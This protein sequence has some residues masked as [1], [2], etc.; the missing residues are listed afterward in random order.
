M[1][2][3]IELY[4]GDE[5]LETGRVACEH[6]ASVCRDGR[7]SISE[8]LLAIDERVVLECV[9]PGRVTVNND[10]SLTVDRAEATATPLA[11]G[12][13]ARRRFGCRS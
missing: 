3:R 6:G 13:V 2:R 5:L 12:A 9:V 4:G 8:S 7:L 10:D 1:R 11:I